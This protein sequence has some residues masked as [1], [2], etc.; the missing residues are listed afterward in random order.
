M[1]VIFSSTDN[2]FDF[3][4]EKW[5]SKLNRKIMGSI[6]VISFLVS[7]TLIEL[8]R[9]GI[10]PES[11]ALHIPHNHF[12]AINF[13]FTL[14]LYFEV[15]DL[16]FG[17]TSSFSKAVGKQFEIFSL[18]L[19]RQSF[20]ELQLIEWPLV[21]EEIPNA[22]LHIFSDSGAALVIF[23]LL[24]VYYRVLRRHPLTSDE[25]ESSSFISAKRAISLVLLLIFNFSAI[26]HAAVLVTMGKTGGF[27]E[28]FYTVLVFSDILIVLI[29][30]YYS[31]SFS[32]V[33]RN[34]GFALS[35]V[36]LR[37]ALAAP[38]YL[39]ALIGVFSAVYILGLVVVYNYYLP[40]EE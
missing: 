16:V 14:L 28:M 40:V 33:F 31:N 22:F 27:F 20:K 37:I 9:F 4:H 5:E 39:N 32:I 21:W 6:L 25:T 23:A 3:L 12:Y 24:A 17:I 18:I 8:V 19:L 2:I 29:S 34:S 26:W 36:L 15:I 10:I 11:S 1:N 7:L 13:S 38:I 30:L 35:T